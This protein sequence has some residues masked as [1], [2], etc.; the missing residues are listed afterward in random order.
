MDLLGRNKNDINEH[1]QLEPDFLTENV[2][3]RVC[4][5]YLK[6]KKLRRRSVKAAVIVDKKS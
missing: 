3:K 5:N 4:I 6:Q 2:Q 1:V